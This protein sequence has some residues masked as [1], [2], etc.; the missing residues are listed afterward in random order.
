MAYGSVVQEGWFDVRTF[1]AVGDDVHDDTA[2]IVAAD[3]AAKAWPGGGG[4]VLFPAPPVAY[5][6]TAELLM[7]WPGHW[8]GD[9][10]TR[11]QTIIRLHAAARSVLAMRTT[12]PFPVD[13][14]T[15]GAAISRATIENLT[16]DANALA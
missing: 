11:D 2:A 6:T 15:H 3:A 16:F 14:G 1:G 4:V 7:N 9:T 5:R 10:S 13:N 12:F 8:T